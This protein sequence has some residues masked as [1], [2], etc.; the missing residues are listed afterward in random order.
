MGNPTEPVPRTSIDYRP[1][2]GSIPIEA[3]DPT[4][5]PHAA[6]EVALKAQAPRRIETPGIPDDPEDPGPPYG[7]YRNYTVQNLERLI[8]DVG[9]EYSKCAQ[10]ELDYR[11]DQSWDKEPTDLDI[12]SAA[13][14]QVDTAPKPQADIARP[15]CRDLMCSHPLCVK[16]RAEHAQREAAVKDTPQPD[17]SPPYAMFVG[18]SDSHVGFV[19]VNA[20]EFHLVR[21]AAKAELAYRL[22]EVKT[23]IDEEGDVPTTHGPLEPLDTPPYLMFKNVNM[24]DLKTEVM[25][26]KSL[27][28]RK[29]AREELTYRCCKA[30]V[31]STQRE[32]AA[33]RQRSCSY[34]GLSQY[35][36]DHPPPTATKHDANK[37]RYDLIPPEAIGAVTQVLTMGAAKYGDRNWEKGMSWGRCFAACMRHLWA[38]WRG[39][40]KDP[41][42]GLSH[43]AHAACNVFFLLAYETRS[44]GDDDRAQEEES[45]HEFERP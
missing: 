41:E 32:A 27:N 43:L 12:V 23:R 44:V 10:K 42:S 18:A 31:E 21:E 8:E 25:E 13:L 1:A 40:S 39:E 3:L 36:A 19:A 29:M 37:P 33:E 28:V 17:E 4:L 38:W 15:P 34:P 16:S 2:D 7:V 30:A 6:L 5:G 26:S 24:A 9:P 20:K 45:L 11:R 35:L 14:E 22:R